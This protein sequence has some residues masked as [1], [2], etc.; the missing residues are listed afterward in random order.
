MS[1]RKISS[2]EYQKFQELIYNEIGI[3]LN[4]TKMSLIES[5]FYK[6]MLYHNTECFEEYYNICMAD[7]SEK[8]QMLDIITTNETYFFREEE[9]FRFLKEYV[10]EY[11]MES[12]LRI[13][14]AA[15]SVGVEAYSIAMVCDNI[16][17]PNKWEIIGTDINTDVI[18]KARMRLYNISWAEKIP[19][20][21]KLKYCLKGKGK[22]EGKFLITK[23][24][25]KNVKFQISNLM[26]TN[27]DLGVFDIVFLRNVLIYF[28]TQT[29]Q[30]VLKSI[31][32]NMRIGSL[33]IIS[34]T[35]NLNSLDL[36]CLE[37]IHPSIFKRIS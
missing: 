35:E 9:H 30:K 25:A 29:R 2:T 26:E 15:S 21:F 3:T 1:T 14:S 28:N 4:E 37:Q 34:Q 13:W 19:S 12:K 20:E 6:R 32:G 23:E 5:R 24:F 22:F 18:K 11:G 36:A 31:M 16:L 33:L 17:P 27:S 7:S 10:Q 8:T